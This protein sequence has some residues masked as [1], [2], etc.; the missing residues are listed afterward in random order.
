M[1]EF[2]IIWHFS[3]L[4]LNVFGTHKVKLINILFVPTVFV[5]NPKE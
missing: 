2:Y 4:G 3:F 5:S 1:N